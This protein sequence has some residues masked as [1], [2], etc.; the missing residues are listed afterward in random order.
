MC[1]DR[2]RRWR[3]V[4]RGLLAIGIAC[5]GWSS[6]V[7]LATMRYQREQQAALERL[8]V[9]VSSP[10][11][12]FSAIVAHGGLI[13]SLDIPGLGLSAII[14]EGDDHATLKV[15]VGHLPET[16]LPWHDG[17]S[18]L[19]AHRDTFFRPLKG[20]RPGD[21]LHLS[22][23]H[24]NF[25]YQVRG[26]MVVGPNDLWV[27]D[28]TGRPTLTLIT[29]YPFNYIGHAP[30][31]FIVHAERVPVEERITNLGPR[32][33]PRRRAVHTFR[34]TGITAYLSNGG[35]LEHGQQ[36]AAPTRSNAS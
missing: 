34:A 26:T 33:Y 3:S 21:E 36:I 35:T 25:T 32:H 27:L 9:A 29:C 18:A 13:G 8:R 11:S 31:R 22:T 28:P 24:G 6:V 10:P 19:A 14:A 30:R 16:P 15:A 1:A 4:A 17:N 5:L 20:I 12:A 23:I 7:A 2:R